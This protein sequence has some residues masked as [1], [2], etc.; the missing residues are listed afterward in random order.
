MGRFMK[1][2]LGVI[3]LGVGLFGYALER[4]INKSKREIT[5]YKQNLKPFLEKIGLL[6]KNV[7]LKDSSVSAKDINKDGVKDYEVWVR[8]DNGTYAERVILGV[9]ADKR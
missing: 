7:I 1:I 4:Q 9:E 2:T 3:V 6:E 8:E 5:N